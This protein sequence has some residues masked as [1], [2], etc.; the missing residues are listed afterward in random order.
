MRAELLKQDQDVIDRVNQFPKD[1]PGLSDKKKAAEKEYKFPSALKAAHAR[2][3]Q[4]GTDCYV[5]SGDGGRNP[6]KRLF[7]QSPS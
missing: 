4:A 7:F 6:E 2:K 1:D 3:A 5:K